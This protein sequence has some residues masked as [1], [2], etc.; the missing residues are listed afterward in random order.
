MKKTLKIKKFVRQSRPPFAPSG[1]R[2][3]SRYYFHVV[4]GNGEIIAASES[5]TTARK[6]NKTA[7]LLADSKIEIEVEPED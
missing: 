1:S 3:P 6:R 2:S 5:Y 4:A 7:K